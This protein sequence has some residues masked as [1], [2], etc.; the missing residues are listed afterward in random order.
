MNF[1]YCFVFHFLLL[2]LDIKSIVDFYQSDF[3]C[4]VNLYIKSV[5]GI[6]ISYRLLKVKKK[7]LAE[8]F[9][10]L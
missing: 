7:S 1:F 8:L 4:L 3:L 5:I 10:A 9:I 6:K 2:L